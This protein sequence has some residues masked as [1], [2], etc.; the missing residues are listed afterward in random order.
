MHFCSQKIYEH[1][2]KTAAI[3]SQFQC[4]PSP[5]KIPECRK[6]IYQNISRLCKSPHPKSPVSVALAVTLLRS[7]KGDS[8]RLVSAYCANQLFELE[9]LLHP[10]SAPLSLAGPSPHPVALDNSNAK[11]FTTCD[12]E[13]EE[14][15]EDD[16]QQNKPPQNNYSVD[17]NMESMCLTACVQAVTAALSQEMLF[18]VL[19]EKAEIILRDGLTQNSIPLNLRDVQSAQT[20]L[21]RTS[22]DGPSTP[23]RLVNSSS[24]VQ[25]SLPAQSNLQNC[26]QPDDDHEIVQLGSSDENDNDDSVVVELIPHLNGNSYHIDE[27]QEDGVEEILVYNNG[28]P[29]DVIEMEIVETSKTGSP[30]KSAPGVETVDGPTVED[31]LSSF[32]DVEPVG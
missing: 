7:G 10:I 5:Y 16:Q 26:M 25:S 14:L 15:H 4:P 12:I 8:T 20:S 28:A 32:V 17:P 24:Y 27:G 3:I 29:R 1:L 30:I 6:L 22:G 11:H 23:N 18:G 21:T 31:M 13:M 19:K 9:R 2:V